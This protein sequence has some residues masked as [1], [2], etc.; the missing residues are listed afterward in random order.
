MTQEV[1]TDSPKKDKAPFSQNLIVTGLV[2]LVG[3]VA[4]FVAGFFPGFSALLLA[5][6]VGAVLGNLHVVPA[7]FARSV[8]WSSKK[9][10]R[11]GI[12]FLGFKLSITSLL[13]IGFQGIIVLVCTVAITFV[14]TILI[15]RLIKVPH[16][17][18][19]LVAT[20]FS[21]CGASAVAAMSSIVDPEEKHEQDTAQA[22]ALVAIYGTISMFVL[23]AFAKA[24][25]LGELQSGLWIGASVHEVA[26]VVAAGAMISTS[27]MAL[28]TV[29]KLGR[30][31]LLAPLIAIVSTVNSRTGKG[32]IDKS[33][34]P[35]I[36]PL[37]VLGFLAAI[38][39]RT[40]VPFPPL[41]FSSLEFVANLLLASAMFGLGFGVDII[42]MIKTGWKPLILGL[43][44]TALAV[45]VSIGLILLLGA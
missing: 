43:L 10:L 19:M 33:K 35:P 26:H 14:G 38:L 44:S 5:I 16:V 36:I 29:A 20:G 7:K 1:K 45:S 32:T 22:I 12:V 27:A 40:F 28:A 34:R 30:V 37:F 31:V 8:Q 24:F 21:I 9:L 3:L 2:L 6:L 4:I 18:R 23:P 11:I 13:Q 25:K 39:V 17:T 15:G 41:V 42:H